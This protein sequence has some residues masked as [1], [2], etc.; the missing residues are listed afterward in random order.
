MT[1]AKSIKHTGDVRGSQSGCDQGRGHRAAEQRR[2]KRGGPR[3]RG[4]RGCSDKMACKKSEPAQLQRLIER[5]HKM[6]DSAQKQHLSEQLQI[7]VFNKLK[8]WCDDNKAVL[9]S[10]KIQDMLLEMAPVCDL[11]DNEDK[12]NTKMWI[13]IHILQQNNALHDGFD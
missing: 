4:G 10:S 9:L 7:R 5:L 13:C 12:L 8:C 1:K 3:R 2:E 11:L 6:S